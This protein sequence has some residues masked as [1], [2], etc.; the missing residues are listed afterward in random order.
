MMRNIIYF[1]LVI[2]IDQIKGKTNEIILCGILKHY[3]EQ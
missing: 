2:E 1:D 3:P